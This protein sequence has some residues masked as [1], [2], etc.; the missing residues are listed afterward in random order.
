MLKKPLGY[1][2]E[3]EL[4]GVGGMAREIHPWVIE[5]EDLQVTAYRYFVA[6]DSQP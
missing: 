4:V 6:I 1:E 5:D 2:V 3:G